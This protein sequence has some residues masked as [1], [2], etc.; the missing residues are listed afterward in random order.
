MK[1]LTVRVADDFY[2]ELVGVARA[3][4]VSLSDLARAQLEALTTVAK[5]PESGWESDAPATLSVVERQQLALLHRILAAGRTDDTEGHLARAEV[6]ERGYVIEYP[7]EFQ[8]IEPELSTR[9]AEF[10]MDVLDMFE[11]LED[12]YNELTDAE[13]E[14]LGQHGQYAVRFRGFDANHRRESRLLG[15]ARHLIEDGRWESLAVYFTREHSHGNSH[16]QTYGTYE[17]MRE[18]FMPIWKQKLRAGTGNRSDYL[19]DADQI[20]QVLRAA[21][22][23]SNR[24]QADQEQA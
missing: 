10:V 15:Y 16:H 14:H 23:P 8:A 17:R 6:L 2:N 19:L 5:P 12:S 1:T 20:A 13:R 4:G 3:R 7:N 9:E 11:R 21:I 18:V 22:H 24:P